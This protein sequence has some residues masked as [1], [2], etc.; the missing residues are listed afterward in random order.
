MRIRASMRLLAARALL[1]SPEEAMTELH[2]GEGGDEYR[3]FGDDTLDPSLAQDIDPKG[4]QRPG[5]PTDPVFDISFGTPAE[6]REQNRRMGNPSVQSSVIKRLAASK[7]LESDE[8]DQGEYS[9]DRAFIEDDVNSEGN[10]RRVNPDGTVTAEPV[11]SVPEGDGDT[12]PVGAPEGGE[13][14]GGGEGGEEGGEGAPG[15]G[16]GSI[17]DVQS[18]MQQVD[19][20]DG[21]DIVSVENQLEGFSDPEGDTLIDADAGSGIYN[22]VNIMPLGPSG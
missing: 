15:G 9:N 10:F 13:D 3:V 22:T 2:P 18:I 17:P 20:G 7:L 4:P 19:E 11:P 1:A 21:A 14:T 5:D 12:G 6:S 16:G 8:A